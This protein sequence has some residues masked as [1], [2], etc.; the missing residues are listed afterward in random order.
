MSQNQ[1]VTKSNNACTVTLIKM[2]TGGGGP[3]S[4]QFYGHHVCKVAHD[5]TDST[6]HPGVA[7]YLTT[8][9]GNAGSKSLP[10]VPPSMEDMS[11]NPAMKNPLL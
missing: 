7:G 8:T 1:I 3:K 6:I 4:E 5:A 9:A 11:N 2:L 10:S